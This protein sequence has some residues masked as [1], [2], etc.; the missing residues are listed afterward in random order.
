M[1]AATPPPQRPGRAA[2]AAACG[3][4][5]G[6]HAA[7]AAT[8]LLPW[9]P[10]GPA[11]TG[12]E[13]A[14]AVALVWAE[15]GLA[16]EG[17]ESPAG[18][19]GTIGDVPHDPLPLPSAGPPDLAEPVPPD[20]AMAA[21]APL[22]ATARASRDALPEPATAPPA[23]PPEAAEEVQPDRVAAVAPPRMAATARAL[24]PPPAPLP[25]E[26]P[27][28]RPAPPGGAA[29][30]R[31]GE[32][33]TLARTGEAA[34]PRGG[35]AAAAPVLPA[36]PVLVTT[37]RY[38]RPPTPPDYP[39]PAIELGLTGTVLVRALV[40]PEGDTREARVW[41]S[42]GHAL[43]DAAA[44]RAVRRWEFEPAS[45]QGRRVAAWVEVPVHFRLN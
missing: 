30:A 8:L 26:A 12:G 16:A 43:L 2:R 33:T 11:V 32:A 40:S 5:L 28:R 39:P 15:S 19:A 42:S 7:L 34:A 27:P 21:A 4:S 37:P 35:E 25:R 45:V 1:A 6:L 44:L 17:A 38:R 24:P 31:M 18:T 20:P 36:G 22:P 29:P 9:S 3:A 41:R 23:D 10:P 13:G 14:E